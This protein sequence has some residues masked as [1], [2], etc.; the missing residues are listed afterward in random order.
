MVD[1]AG[2]MQGVKISRRVYGRQGH[3]QGVKISRRYLANLMDLTTFSTM[4]RMQM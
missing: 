3:M 2:R 4:K 1:K